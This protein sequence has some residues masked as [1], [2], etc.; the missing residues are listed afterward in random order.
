MPVIAP[1]RPLGKDAIENVEKVLSLLREP[2]HN[3]SRAADWL[4][5]WIREDLPQ[6]PLLSVDAKLVCISIPVVTDILFKH[7][8][9]SVCYIYIYYI[10]CI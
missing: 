10:I 6:L 5:A 7:I 9:F 1:H 3:L 8:P 4:E 2:V